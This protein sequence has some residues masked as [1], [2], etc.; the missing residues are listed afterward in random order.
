M[1][2]RYQ[3]F[4]NFYDQVDELRQQF[5]EH[6]S[7]SAEHHPD[8]H[9]I[10]QF[11]YQQNQYTYFTTE[12]RNVIQAPLVDR[13]V[14]KLRAWSIETMGLGGISGPVFSFYVNGCRQGLHNDVGAGRWGYVFSL[15]RWQERKFLGGETLVFKDS[16]YADQIGLNS[17]DLN[18]DSYDLIPSKYNQLLIFDD[19]V[20]HAVPVIQGL[21]DPLEGR[22]VM[23]GHISGVDTYV[24]GALTEDRVESILSPALTELAAKCSAMQTVFDGG[25]SLRLWITNAGSVDS[26]KVLTS[27]VL[28]KH[29]GKESLEDLIET[30]QNHFLKLKFPEAVRQSRVTIPLEINSDGLHWFLPVRRLAEYKPE[31]EDWINA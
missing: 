5:E 9:A 7:L 15:T 31:G 17:A 1:N 21:L 11:F 28:K 8:T 16:N 10:W 19:R 4:E 30:I 22:L 20:I 29:R 25:I 13:F 6:F 23:H 12:P 14:E 26:C 27:R 2:E 18:M 24:D 3:V